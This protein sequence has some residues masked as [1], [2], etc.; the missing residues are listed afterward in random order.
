MGFNVDLW[1]CSK[2]SDNP[3]FFTTY[4]STSLRDYLK[5][6][7]IHFG[8]FT[9]IDAHYDLGEAK[10]LQATFGAISVYFC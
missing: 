4:Y 3:P 7:R 5:F 9:G 1:V 6:C 2:I 10:P 8:Q